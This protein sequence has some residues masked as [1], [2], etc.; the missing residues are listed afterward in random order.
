MSIARIYYE[1]PT[2]HANSPPN[3][4]PEEPAEGAGAPPNNPVFNGGGFPAG[5]CGV[6]GGVDGAAGAPKVNAD[7]AAAAGV[8]EAGVEVPKVAVVEGP[9]VTMI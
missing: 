5:V 8:V 2:S 1:A 6:I 3:N 7:G 9:Q 4:P